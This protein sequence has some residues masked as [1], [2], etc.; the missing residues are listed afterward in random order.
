MKPIAQQTILLT[1]ATDG[2]GKQTA[3]ALARQ[4]A[5]L[6]LH[7]RDPQRLETTRQ[8]IRDATGNSHLETY[9][10]DF[11]SLAQVRSLAQAVQAKHPRLDLLINNAGIGGGKSGE[12][13]REVSQDGY[14]LRFAVNYLAPFLLTHLL[15][16][17]LRHTPPSRIINVSSAGQVP[18][19]F[20][21][22]ML[23]RHYDPLNA[24]RQSKLAQVMFTFDL[25]EKLKEEQITVNCL[26]PASLMN[27]K[28][29]YESFGYTLSTIEDGVNALMY[30]ATSPD[31]DGV[32]GKYFDQQQESRANAQAYDLAA[33]HQ[34]RQLS[35]QLTGL[36]GDAREVN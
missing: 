31:L 16:P 22:V 29:V 33:R 1:G 12:A 5:T 27:T 9:R 23:E 14:E 4:G 6:L 10:A 18:L 25:A 3:L 13:R 26:H 19:D 7:G 24:Y 20:G 15:L 32:T 35:E 17:C 30:L 34:L 28:M 2:L 36:S 11:A 21:D 8:E